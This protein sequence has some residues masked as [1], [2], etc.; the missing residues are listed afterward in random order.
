M[1]DYSYVYNAHPAYIESMYKN[2]QA[3]PTSVDEGWRI[4][5][6]GFEFNSN[7]DSE[8]TG[9]QSSDGKL[10]STKEFGV[11]SLIHG[12]RSRGHL[13]STTNPIKPRK[14]RKPYLNINDFGL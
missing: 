8:T 5:F 2:Y 11:I 12:F 7:T 10:L 13:L 14:D 9:L 1:K 3:D 6:D 4:F